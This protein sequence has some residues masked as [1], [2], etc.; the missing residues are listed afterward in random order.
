MEQKLYHEFI[1]NP[2]SNEG[3]Y[4][5]IVNPTRNK[6]NQKQSFNKDF[7]DKGEKNKKQESK[8]ES[9][10]T[11]KNKHWLYD[12]WIF[13]LMKVLT[14]LVATTYVTIWLLEL[15]SKLAKA[16]KNAAMSFA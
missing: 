8:R 2:R 3:R 9:Y 15:V 16:S 11:N 4:T 14:T 13:R 6:T 5:R 7:A 12:N 10:Q 1:T